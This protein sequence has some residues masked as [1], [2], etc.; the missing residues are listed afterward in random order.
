MSRSGTL[1]ALVAVA[2]TAIVGVGVGRADAAVT[3]R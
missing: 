1:V 3:G 2:L